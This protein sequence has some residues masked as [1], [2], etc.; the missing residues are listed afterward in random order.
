MSD[1]ISELKSKEPSVVCA[2]IETLEV[3]NPEQLK[4]N[5]V[6]LLLNPNAWVRSRAT[7][8][9]CRWDKSEAIR[10]LASML[11]SNKIL[12]REAALNNSIFF[13][14]NQ[15]ES[16]LLKFLT[17]EREQNLIQKAGVVFMVNPDKTTAYRLF[18][19]K[20]A[21]RGL[22]SNLIEAILVGVLNSLFQAK[23]DNDSPELQLKKLQIEYNEKKTKIYINHFS[24]MLGSEDSSI[25]LKA[26]LKLCELIKKNVPGVDIIINEF[27]KT[28]EEATV[29]NQ[30]RFFLDSDKKKLTT[31]DKKD[32]STLDG[33][34]KI[35][36]SINKDNYSQLI[37]LL[38]P[39]LRNLPEIEQIR[40]INFVKDYG[41]KS[42]SEQVLKCL[43]TNNPDVQQAV[44]DCVCKIDQEALNPYL[45]NLIKSNYDQVKLSAI[46][47]F[48][49]FDKPQALSILGQMMTSIKI[50]Q[51]K[52]ALFCLE[53]LDFASVSDII[54][55]AVKQEKEVSIRKELYNVLLDNANEEVFY[56]IYFHYMTSNSNEKIELKSFLIKYS[57]KL[58]SQNAGKTK[59]DFWEN[60]EARWN[61]EN[62]NKAQR[63]AY[64]LEKIQSLIAKDD[65]KEKIE[66]VKFA[67]IS[68]SIGFILTLLI[69]FGFMAPNAWFKTSDKATEGIVT[70]EGK[71]QEVN[72][73]PAEP[74]T[75]KGV[76][77]EVSVQN[78]QAMFL[79]NTGKKYLLMFGD[80][81]SVPETGKEITAQI[82]VEDYENSVYIADVI[83]L[84]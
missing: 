82:L 67:F 59:D 10:Y 7:R 60:A 58:A 66:L 9:M 38:L 24:S 80:E 61:E 84:L 52:N 25:R 13:P 65:R 30:V 11:F 22:R 20:Q 37:A 50:S 39:I 72:L 46:N 75:V 79:D 71:N 33:R 27:L 3:S 44:I 54:I 41:D 57:Q 56:E 5:I 8:A 49:L 53:S 69:W 28:E 45:P 74:I 26:A 1:L 4:A 35:Y 47:A 19:A 83:S 42:Q 15:I 68:H 18:E 62:E 31:E 40:I 81:K 55:V 64:K 73:L 14:F 21:T 78:L 36:S 12:E 29:V 51:R 63:E 70:E 32:V 34:E 17:V 16:L 76:I 77:L 48:T 23:L 43:E 6:P 2:A